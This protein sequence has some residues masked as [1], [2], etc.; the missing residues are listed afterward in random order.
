MLLM[1]A[2]FVVIVAGL[3]A[4]SELLVPVMLG[5]FLAVLSLPIL[6]WFVRKNVPR[7]LAIGL[8]VGID[9]LILSGL[10]LL[11]GSVL[12]E[13]QDKRLD[14]AN[15]LQKR[16]AEFTK[17]VDAQL[18]RFSAFMDKFDLD[19]LPGE[20]TAAATD[21][22]A[23]PAA[24]VSPVAVPDAGPST[25]VPPVDVTPPLAGD[26]GTAGERPL[27]TFNE[28]FNRYWDSKIIVEWIGQTE[29]VGRITSLASKSF[30]V[31]I[32][33]IFVLGESG[34]FSSTVRQVIRERGP[35]L[36]RF[37]NSSKDIQKYLGIKTIVSAVT[38]VLAGGC[39][40]IGVDFPILW[41]L[42]AFI[43]NYVPAV[44]SIVAAIP[45]IILAL[46]E[47]GFWP[48]FAVL[49]VYLAI[50]VTIGNFIEPMLLGDRFGISTTVVI[51][52]VL[53]WGYVW[54]PVGMFLAVPLTMMVKVM[55][56]NSHE[57]RWISVLLNSPRRHTMAVR[58]RA[59]RR[60]SAILKPAETASEGRAAPE[61]ESGTGSTVT[62]GE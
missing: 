53:F 46:V 49:I 24:P 58:A 22:G 3:R 11:A 54:G 27:L 50:N 42:V 40:A 45:P 29:L 28:L 52:S 62:A 60:I 61:G 36:R 38:G 16:T 26:E 41:G 34:N 15:S 43:F 21:S 51:L 2:A 20:G 4:A 55:L 39:A 5:L 47:Q 17:T 32:I 13:F 37:Q 18:A 59:A 23:V 14:Y 31:L 19:L 25:P 56:E 33:M 44:G 57:L 12:P 48:A 9:F 1:L 6:N 30:F 10:I 7:P 35:D 8:T